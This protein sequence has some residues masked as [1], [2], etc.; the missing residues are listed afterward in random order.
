LID[1][2]EFKVVLEAILGF[3]FIRELSFDIN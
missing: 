1:V 2:Q 3:W